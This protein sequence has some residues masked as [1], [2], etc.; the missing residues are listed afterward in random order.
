MARTNFYVQDTNEHTIEIYVGE[1]EAKKNN[2]S[3]V[4]QLDERLIIFD[5]STGDIVTFDGEH[6]QLGNDKFGKGDLPSK[7]A[8]VGTAIVGKD[9]VGPSHTVGYAIVGT[10]EVGGI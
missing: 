3:K 7:Y 9:I 4:L 1:E 5:E 6:W 2:I 10:D 8:V